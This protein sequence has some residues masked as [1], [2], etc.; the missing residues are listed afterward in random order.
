[1]IRLLRFFMTAALKK[2]NR[3]SSNQEKFL[4]RIRTALGHE[5]D[6]RRE[7]PGLFPDQPST[8][9]AAVLDRL[10]QR[11]TEGRKRLLA[12]MV[13]AGKPINLQVM[14]VANESAATAAIIELVRSK[15]PEWENQNHVAVW[16]HPLLEALGLAAAFE[17]EGIPL[18]IVDS[19]PAENGESIRTEIR[20]NIVA[21]EPGNHSLVFIP[22]H[23]DDSS[24]P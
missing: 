13:E 12:Q 20:R 24:S 11:D 7:M 9:S 6:T 23:L 14:S 8:E 2:N 4:T 19:V 17:A 16:Q 5:P 21:C 22:L 18:Y 15:S 3:M 10:R 1:M